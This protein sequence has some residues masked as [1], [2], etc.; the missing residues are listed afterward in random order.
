M[1]TSLPAPG[2]ELRTPWMNAAGSLGFAPEARGSV[3]WEQF[4]AFVTNP[5]SARPRRASHGVR[6]V[7]FPGGVLLHTGHPNPGLR[8]AIKQYGSAWARAPLPVIIHLLS[9][10]P[11]ELHKAVLRIEELENILAVELGFESDIEAAELRDLLHAAQ[12]EIPLVAQLPGLHATRLVEI[13]MDA[14]VAAVSLAAP[15]GT[16][17]GP[18]GKLVSGR[19]YGPATLPLTIE[20]VRL[21]APLGIPLFASGGFQTRAEG[22]AALAAGATGVQVDNTALWAGVFPG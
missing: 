4:G 9:T 22:E 15:R 14:G 16:L 5:L 3:D 10:K 17:P 13:A 8:T 12:G 20:T 6:S 1:S 2:I 11:E 19:L 7:E 21:L 18:D